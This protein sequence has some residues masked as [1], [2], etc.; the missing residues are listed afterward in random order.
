MALSLLDLGNA[1]APLNLTPISSPSQRKLLSKYYSSATV[2]TRPEG[3]LA[4][5]VKPN[6]GASSATAERPPGEGE[7][8]GAGAAAGG[9]AAGGETQISFRL[10]SASNG[11]EAGACFCVTMTDGTKTVSRNRSLPTPFHTVNIELG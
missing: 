6:T 4:D 8:A 1:K 11:Q 9:P 2:A 5:P 3:A 10:S 7:A